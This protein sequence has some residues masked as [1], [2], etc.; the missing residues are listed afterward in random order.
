MSSKQKDLEGGDTREWSNTAQ[1][2]DEWSPENVDDMTEGVI[3]TKEPKPYIK[4]MTWEDDDGKHSAD[5]PYAHIDI[6]GMVLPCKINKFSLGELG[7]AWGSDIAGWD[8]K[9][10]IMTVAKNK[11]YTFLVVKPKPNQADKP[12]K[13]T[14][15]KRST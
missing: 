12:R 14:K 5:K 2:A 11:S 3:L 4:T 6:S 7:K 13:T 1:A 9:K 10:V 15:R 8:G